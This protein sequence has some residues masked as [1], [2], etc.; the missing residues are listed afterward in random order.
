[1]I[2]IANRNADK[3]VTIII[4][5]TEFSHCLQFKGIFIRLFIFIFVRV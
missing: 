1:M 5:Q 4:K 2:D 3:A